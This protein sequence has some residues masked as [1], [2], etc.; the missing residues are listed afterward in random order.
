MP[1]LFA[2]SFNSFNDRF[3]IFI[4]YPNE[5]FFVTFWMDAS[6][7]VILQTL[8]KSRLMIIFQTLGTSRED[9]HFADFGKVKI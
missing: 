2:I 9:S 6:W 7:M 5:M 1:L 4:L 8:D 3:I